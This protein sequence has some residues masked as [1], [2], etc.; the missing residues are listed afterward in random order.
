MVSQ[1]ICTWSVQLH[2][3]AVHTWRARG[4]HAG[5]RV[6]CVSE[7]GELGQLEAHEASHLM[8]QRMVRWVDVLT[9]RA[10]LE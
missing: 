9:V 10:S 7:D 8:V 5:G 6:H 2:I 1:A 4:L 3:R